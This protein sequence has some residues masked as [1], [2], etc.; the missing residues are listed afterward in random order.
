M[1]PAL[2]LAPS[3]LLLASAVLGGCGHRDYYYHRGNPG[4]PFS[5]PTCPSATTPAKAVAIDTDATLETEAGQG[6]G[7]LVEYMAGGHWHIWTVC[8]TAISGYSCEFD[9]T[10][11]AIGANVSNLLAEELE[12]GDVATSYCAD[13]AILGATTRVDFDGIWFDTHAGAT[14]RVTA[15]LGQTLYENVFFWKSGGVVHED[16][17]ANPVEFTP[18]AP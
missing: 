7:V 3:L 17:N 1:G 9:I 10:G 4:R 16:A 6:A 12:S 15:A 18:L 11:Q 5:L 13:T 2:P 14:V 8:D